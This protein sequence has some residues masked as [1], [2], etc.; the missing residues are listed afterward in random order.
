MTYVAV[1]ANQRTQTHNYRYYLWVYELVW[2][3][4]HEDWPSIHMG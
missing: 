1:A 2:R 4:C 3:A